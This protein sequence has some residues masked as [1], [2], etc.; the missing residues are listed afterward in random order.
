MSDSLQV[1]CDP[2][3]RFVRLPAKPKRIV[4][5][6]SGL[7]EALFEI[8]YGPQVVGVSSYCSRYITNLTAPVVG[9]YLDVDEDQLRR[10]EPDLVLT[11]AGVQRGLGK[12]L[13]EHGF[14]V[15]ALPLPNSLHG[16][17]E[18]LV[19]L[20]AL[21]DEIEAARS[22]SR[23][24][25]SVFSEMDFSAPAPRPRIYAEC[26]LGKYVRMIG[27]FTFIQDILTAAGAENI[28][29]QHRQG[30]MALDIEAVERL[31]PDIVLFFSEPDYPI[32]TKALLKERGWNFRVIES[33]VSRGRNIIHDGPSMLETAAWLR[34]EIA[35][36]M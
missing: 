4:S 10:L 9:D 2:L 18:N 21:V 12:K 28:F 36:Q 6:V 35:G 25:N 33:D 23:R 5:L 17:L 26:W 30:Y 27:G 19:T 31:Q 24:W 32:D 7:T 14:P 3:G 1:Y 16:V 22:L 20:G 15:Y 34:A 13:A 8:G 11:T 29:G